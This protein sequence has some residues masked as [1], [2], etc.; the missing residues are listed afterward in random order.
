MGEFLL[1]FIIVLCVIVIA[2]YA[3]NAK[4]KANQKK[5]K[6]CW[7]FDKDTNILTIHKQHPSFAKLFHYY[8]Y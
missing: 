1:Y 8:E 5:S 4:S 7:S 2:L 6:D 3:D